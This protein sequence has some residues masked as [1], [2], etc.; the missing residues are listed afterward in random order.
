MS[1]DTSYQSTLDACDKIKA[2]LDAAVNDAELTAA[3][4]LADGLGPLLPDDAESLG[5]AGDLVSAIQAAKAAIATA[6]E[7]A[8]ALKASVE[9]NHGAANE[10]ATATGHMAER[11]FHTAG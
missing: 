8:A 9:K 11:E 5:H 6:M 7:Q 10:A 2:A 1:G 4:S 3:S